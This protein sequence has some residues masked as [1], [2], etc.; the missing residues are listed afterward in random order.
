MKRVII[1]VP[2]L[3]RFSVAVLRR[4]AVIIR[5]TDPEQ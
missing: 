4:P 5:S 1:F 2:D 3:L